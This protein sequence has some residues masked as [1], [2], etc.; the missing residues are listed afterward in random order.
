MRVHFMNVLIEVRAFFYPQIC[1]V[2]YPRKAC[3]LKLL[4]VANSA[5]VTLA[6]GND[7][8]GLHMLEFTSRMF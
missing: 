1:F 5:N 7:I 3:T 2:Q 4:V 8:F 6:S